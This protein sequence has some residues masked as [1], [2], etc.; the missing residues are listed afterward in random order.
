[1]LLQRSGSYND[2][3]YTASAACTELH[4]ACLQ[5]EQRVIATA[6]NACAGV[7]MGTALADDDLAGLNDLTAEA[8]YAQVL[9]V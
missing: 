9:S 8:L 2:V 6:A 1:V 3:H 5:S 7:E 4:R